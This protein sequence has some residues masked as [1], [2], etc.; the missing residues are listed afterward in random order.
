MRPPEK[1]SASRSVPGPAGPAPRS[2][3]VPGPAP[4]SV[5]RASRRSVRVCLLAGLLALAPL[6]AGAAPAQATGEAAARASVLPA[7]PAPDSHGLALRSWR[8]VPGFGGRLGEATFLTDAIFRPAGPGAPSIDP[9]RKPVKAR[10]LLPADYDP[11]QQYPVL[12]L[13]HGGAADVEQWSKP[14]GGDIVE[15]LRGTAFNG[16]VVMPEGGKAGWYSDWQGH[17]DGNFA[18][19]WETFHIRRLLPWVDA[20]FATRTDRSGRAV[21]GASMGGLGALKYA[22]AHPDLFSAVGAFSG[23]TDIRPAAAQQ[24]V[25]DSLWFYGAAFSW[26]GLLDGKY[27]V[28]GSTSY[29]MSTVFGPS[30]GWAAFNPVQVAGSEASYT[31]YDGRLA[32]YAGTGEADI[33]GWNEDLHRPLRSRGVAH[34]YCTGPGGHEMRLWREELRN[35]VDYVYGSRARSCPNG[36]A[37]PAS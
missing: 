13:L 12:Y 35:F 5:R 28:T 29:R 20:N 19:R 10:I 34:R 26:T 11:R 30:S 22:A 14:D 32:L 33:H 21:A 1:S 15:T 6:A 37:P 31:A 27:R 36:W 7:L 2:V 9:V 18:P 17:T 4:G 25:G 23:G 3:P 16:I 8:E 24:T